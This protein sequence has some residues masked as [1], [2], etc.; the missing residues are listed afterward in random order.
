MD[1]PLRF[2]THCETVIAERQLDRA[3]VE[4][5]VRHPDWRED[6]PSGPPVER[7]FS[8]IPQRE[9]RILRVVCLETATEIRIITAFLDRKARQPQ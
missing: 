7:R 3:W 8:I 9:N 6:D 2:T 5:T 1:K 4:E